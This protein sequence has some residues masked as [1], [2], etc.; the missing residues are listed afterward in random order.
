MASSVK[1]AQPQPDEGVCRDPLSLPESQQSTYTAADSL[2][3][4]ALGALPPADAVVLPVMPL[5]VDGN[6][7]C[8]RE[9]RWLPRAF[10]SSRRLR[11]LSTMLGGFQQALQPE[12]P[13][14]APS[15]A[16]S[17]T[18]EDWTPQPMT[19]RDRGGGIGLPPRAV[20]RR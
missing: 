20:A 19:F 17:A 6:V 9:H 14:N 16:M 15:P 12:A 4:V 7:R 11:P 8:L 18:T 10:T 2:G 5:Q 1:I 3:S 13:S